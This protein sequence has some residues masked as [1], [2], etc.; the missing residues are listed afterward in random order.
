MPIN[1]R[2]PALGPDADTATLVKWMFKVGDNVKAGDVLAEISNGKD[3]GQIKAAA[4][5]ILEKVL[6]PAGAESVNVRD[7]VAVIADDSGPPPVAP[8][9]ARI[10]I[11]PTSLSGEGTLKSLLE[12]PCN[13]GRILAG[14]EALGLFDAGSYE[15]IPHDGMRKTIARRLVASKQTVPHFYIGID[16]RIDELLALR[17]KLNDSA[18]TLDD[19]QPRYKLSVN[20]M[21]IRALA[22]AL[23]D[24]PD[25]NVS[26]TESEMV[27]HTC[28]DVGVAVSIPGGLITP[29][30][31]K[32]ELKSL[33]V[34]SNEMKDLVKRAKDRKLRPEEYQGGTTTISNMGMMG[35]RGFAA[36]I[37]PPQA[38]ILAVGAG[39]E[40]VISKNGVPTSAMVMNVVLSV[41][42]RCLDGALGAR[43][44]GEFKDYIENPTSMIV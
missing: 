34:I 10:R 31:R 27:R 28:S 25:A 4:A 40:R 38:S 3:T 15:T 24:V 17:A 44:L 20:D 14:S 26:W 18:E 30:I 22:L 41:D 7:L 1:V 37:N 29:I 11:E 13:A 6:V 21:I 42:H 35:V 16:C 43:L 33:Q 5:G 2:M 23:K 8:H 19:G 9:C 32:A 36:I 12:E 39:E